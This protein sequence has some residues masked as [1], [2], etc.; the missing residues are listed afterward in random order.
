MWQRKR[1]VI[2]LDQ[3][4]EK[5]QSVLLWSDQDRDHVQSNKRVLDSVERNYKSYLSFSK[6]LLFVVN[7]VVNVVV[8]VVVNFVNVVLL[9]LLLLLLWMLGAWINH[10]SESNELNIENKFRWREI[11][12]FLDLSIKSILWSK[13]RNVSRSRNSGTRQCDDILTWITLENCVQYV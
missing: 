5:N 7:N 6:M 9:L 8:I 11:E 1:L 13:V 12:L 10:K 4:F 3:Q 2:F